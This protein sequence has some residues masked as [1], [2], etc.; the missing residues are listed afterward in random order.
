MSI[1]SS[2]HKIHKILK[3]PIPCLAYRLARRA[4]V[5]MRYHTVH[6]TGLA[7]YI[8]NHISEHFQNRNRVVH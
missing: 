8:F 3:L 1:S 5:V 7:L 2:G 4:C 6:G